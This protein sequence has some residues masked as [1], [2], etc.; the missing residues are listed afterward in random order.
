MRLFLS[1][2]TIVILM[3]TADATLSV[4]AR[5][6][7]RYSY[8]AS[9]PM[10]Q[11]RIF[12]EGVISTGDYD[13][14]P[15]FSPDGKTLYFLKCTA[16][17]KTCTICVSHFKNDRWTEPTVA[18]F[19]GQYWDVDPFVT[20][21]G[22]TVYFSS[23]RPLKEGASAKAD[24]DIWKVEVT[25]SGWGSPVRLDS[26]INSEGSEYYPTLA[27]NGTFYFGSTRDGSKGGSDIYRCALTNGKYA[28]AENLGDSIN[29]AD[30]E[31]EPFIAPDE[32][33]LIFMATIPQGLNNGDLYFSNNING[34]WSKAEKLPAP[35]NSTGTEWSPKVTRDGQYFFFSSAR[36]TQ[37]ISPPSAETIEQLTKRL[38]RA[39]NGLAD[40][41][42]VD[43]SA[44][45]TIMKKSTASLRLH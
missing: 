38:R 35:F 4:A 45:K 2:I 19:S 15:A 22:K 27:D 16:D 32:S 8:T 42:Q 11:P 28:A 40:I 5:R 17:I 29:T 25:S 43:F 30:N 21:D 1:I 3:S 44:V 14:H 41:Y 7:Q 9:A 34:R 20:K 33:Y 10:P 12:A 13:T 18:P 39:G 31:F 36:N 37:S 24:T 6:Q 26:P 23:N